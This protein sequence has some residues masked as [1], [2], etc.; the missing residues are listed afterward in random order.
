[1]Q[2]AGESPARALPEFCILHFLT[3]T[4]ASMKRLGLITAVS[5][6][7]AAAV[8]AQSNQRSA[9]PAAVAP[10][11]WHNINRDSGATRFSPLNQINAGNVAKLTQSW[12]FTMTG[13]GSSVPLVVNGV[14]YVSSG[15]RVV[16]IDGDT[17]KEVWAFTLP[18]PAPAAAPPTDAQPAVVAAPPANPAPPLPAPAGQ[19]GAAA[20]AQGDGR[21][22]GGPGGGGR[23]G[24]G[25]TASQRGV[26]YWPG[27]GTRAARILFMGGNRLYAVDA[28]TGQPSAGFGDNGSIAVGAV[29]YGGTPTIYRNVAI[30][31]AATQEVPQGPP[32]NPRAFDVITGKKLWEFWSVAQPGQPGHETWGMSA[33][34]NT[35]GWQRRSGANMWAFHAPVDAERGIVYIPIGSPATNYYGGDRPGNNAY[36]NSIIAVEAQTG[37]YLWHFQTVHHDIWDT[38]MPT[39]GALFD[40]VQGGRRIPA[41]AHV[42]K[43][44]YVYVLDRLTG[45][46]LIEVKE[47][48]VPAGD[49]PTEWYSPTQPIPVRPRPLSRV[50]F[51]PKIDLVR[52]EDTTPEH[53]AAC[54]AMMERAGGYY[55][56]GPFT[57][58][59]FKALDAP[60]KSTIQTPGGT[61]GVNWG[62]M[63]MDPT[64][65][66]FYVNAQNT[67]LVGWTQPRP[68]TPPSPA[69]R[70]TNGRVDFAGESAG[71]DHPY[72]RGSVP[73]NPN[74][75]PL[76]P[77]FTFSAPLNGKTPP[78]AP[79]VRPPWA[80]LYAVNASTG[81]ILWEST[82]GLNTNLPEGKQLAGSGGSAGPTATAGGLVF[83]GATSD[84]RFRAFDAKTGKELWV[85]RNPPNAQGNSPAANANPMSYLGRNGKQYVAVVAGT[86]LVAYSLP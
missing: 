5:I 84:G 68:L 38:D 17:G 12:T 82:L 20:P 15:R 81:Q 71:S 29:S 4:G 72:D 47:T 59:M 35:S 13:G 21:R 57:P 61:G 10:G 28:A 44:S 32:G 79:C 66:I 69:D 16:A 23:A 18:A 37:K 33:S 49:V 39:A 65:G 62:G 31:G 24:G 40:F 83:V 7:I 42:G 6:G 9:S 34:H 43:S 52:P 78:N 25:P 51:D 76:G 53:V 54:V 73:A 46:P 56:A 2:N 8:F 74:A 22:G 67:T 55:N 86:T 45:K 19:A 75:T 30:I 3:S 14:M 11:D 58:F 60:P 41:I 1:M 70:M 64:T 26:S 77:F 48:P 36:G 80:K 85:T 27:D 63:S 50:S